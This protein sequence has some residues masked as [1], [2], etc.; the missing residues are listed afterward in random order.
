MA[1]TLSD[2]QLRELSSLGI[3]IEGGVPIPQ[4]IEWAYEGGELFVLQSRKI[5][6]LK[7]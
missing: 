5:K 7:D 2:D 3:R 4:D 1:A 6:G